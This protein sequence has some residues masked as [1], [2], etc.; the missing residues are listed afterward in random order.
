M[1]IG[2]DASRAF[3]PEPT[4]TENYARS[5]IPELVSLAPE[6]QWIL[7][8][9]G[10]RPADLE[11]LPNVQLRALRFP[12]LWTHLRLSAEMTSHPPDRLF[13]PSHVLPLIHPRYSAVTVHDL[14]YLYYPQAH[15]ARDRI[16]L[17]LSTRWNARSARVVLA[18]SEATRRDLVARYD[19][20]P[21]KVVVSYPGLAPHFRPVA[22]QTVEAA[23]RQYDLGEYV[24]AV[25]TL[26][27]RK[28]YGR[29]LEAFARLKRPIT[30]VIVGRKGWL[31]N[32]I[33]D[34]AAQLGLDRLRFLDYVPLADLPSLYAGARAFVF[35]SLYEG[36]G[37]P[38]IEAMACGTPVA[39]SNVSSLPEVGGEAALYFD[40]MDT[41]ALQ[42]AMEQVLDDDTVRSR[43]V[44]RGLQN[45]TRFA[46]VSCA[47][48]VLQTLSGP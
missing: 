44:E 19:V 48:T 41:G 28:N 25:G 22:A 42:A 20:P 29:L 15:R 9:R 7:Y 47:R 33:L 38:V 39:C 30:L 31:Y 18:D 17:D 40:P 26:Q 16:Y 34:R 12:R 3:A 6:T 35:P 8:T 14:G 36:F 5:L 2:I 10:E 45:V 37:L 1:R 24:L 11:D 23:R 27:P 21:D 32:S 43:C 4:G 13:V 46:W